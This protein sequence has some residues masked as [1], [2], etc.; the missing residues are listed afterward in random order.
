MVIQR[1]IVIVLATV[2]SRDPSA[3]V[4]AVRTRQYH[5]RRPGHHQGGDPRRLGEGH[6]HG[7]QRDDRRRVV[8]VRRLQRRQPPAGHAIASRRRCRA[9]RSANVEGIRLTAGATARVDVTLNLGA[10]AES[11]NVVARSTLMQTEDAKVSTNI[12]NEL[13]D[14][15]PLVVGGAMRS[16]FDLVS[17]VPEAKG[18][19]TNVVLGRRPGR[20][21]RRDARRHLGEHQSQRRRRR[22][23]VPDAFGRSDHR[24]LGRDQRLQARIRAGGRRRHHVR[25]EVGHQQFQGSLYNFLRNDALDEKGFFEQTKGIYRQNNFG[26]VLG[27]AGQTAAPLRRQEQDVLLCRL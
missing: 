27:R 19:G 18:S 22:D 3:F 15:L 25:L 10:I 24:V 7:D 16:V 11:V 9:S 14:Q 8:G 2:G 4:R 20:G 26:G 17:T 12:S 1:S 6:Q 21:V 5:R 13:I 23:R